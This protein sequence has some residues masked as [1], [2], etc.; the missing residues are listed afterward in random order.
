MK[1]RNLLSYAFKKVSFI[2]VVILLL[3]FAIFIDLILNIFF[4]RSILLFSF[5]DLNE[6]VSAKRG[7]WGDVLSG[8]FSALAFIAVAYS[9]YL[10][11][12]DI[13]QERAYE[14]FKLS[15]EIMKDLEMKQDYIE[16]IHFDC[17]YID[18]DNVYYMNKDIHF[19]TI[20]DLSKAIRTPD[21]FKHVDIN[22]RQL[23]FL[24]VDRFNLFYTTIKTLR[25]LLETNINKKDI[26]ILNIKLDQYKTTIRKMID[27]FIF[28][29]DT[30][31]DIALKAITT[32][33]TFRILLDIL[34]EIDFEKSFENKVV[35]F[36]D[37]VKNEH[38]KLN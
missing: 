4:D 1:N 35:Y 37:K 24:I 14:N 15:L 30:E 12:K 8:H 10:Q 32:S 33:E 19:N 29:N 28:C 17:K 31:T 22:K 3:L 13:A 21:F 16:N 36:L 26:D 7:Q 20:T 5:I 6:S 34:A 25:Y 38:F 23:N 11:R 18:K 9:I 2:N 27:I